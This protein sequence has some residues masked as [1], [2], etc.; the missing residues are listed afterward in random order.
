MPNVG[1]F[2]IACYSHAIQNIPLLQLFD[3]YRTTSV[4][5]LALCKKLSSLPEANVHTMAPSQD[6]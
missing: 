2:W 6:I 5:Q 1:M 3:R 4:K